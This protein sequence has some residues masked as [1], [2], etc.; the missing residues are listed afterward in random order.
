MGRRSYAR[1]LA[2]WMNGVFV[3]TWRLHPQSGDE[4]A[5]DDAWVQRPEGRALSLSL[6]FQP[7]NAPHRGEAVRAYFDNLLPDSQAIRERVA[8]R[9]GA[10]STGAFDLLAQIGRDCIGALQILPLGESPTGV[11]TIAAEPLSSAQMAHLLRATVAPA[12]FNAA[13]NAEEDFRV[14][15]AGAQEKTALL[16]VDGQWC[17]PRGSTPTSHILKLPLG[18]VGHMQA[19]MRTSVENEW[20]CSLLLKAYG[21]PVANCW[22]LVVEDQKVLC[23][24]RFDRRWNEAGPRWLMRLPQEDMCQAT[25]TP[26]LKKYEKDGGPGML[27]IM[28]LLDGSS[29]RQADHLVFFQAQVLFWMLCAPDG[30]AKNFSIALQPYGQYHMTPL[31][32]VLSAYPLLGAGPGKFSSKK[33][34]LAM[35]VRTKN[36]H[37]RVSEIMRRHW[38]QLGRQFGVIAPNGA[39]ADIV[40]DELV[41]RT[42]GVIRSVQAQLPDAFPHDV[43]DSIFAGLQAAADKLAS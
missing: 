38:V 37:Y 2:L 25:A 8:R 32:D 40:I 1:A 20:L 17:L 27:R 4:L 39:N 15:I 9:F 33:I 24:E 42:P 5:Y 36:T 30:H 41:G 31:Y 26:P 11:Q 28:D 6:P 19:D 12:A 13:G 43:A 34:T 16:Q 18:L 29:R 14:S 3:G 35:A 22:P 10:D 23:V 21:L 7:G